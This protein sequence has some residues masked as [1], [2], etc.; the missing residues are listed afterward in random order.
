MLQL[1]LC[2]S[3]ME[4]NIFTYVARQFVLWCVH[5]YGPVCTHT[6]RELKKKDSEQKKDKHAFM[7]EDIDQTGTFQ[8][9]KEIA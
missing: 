6:D 4:G 3:T 8:L 5:D 7:W 1:L 2:F 9:W